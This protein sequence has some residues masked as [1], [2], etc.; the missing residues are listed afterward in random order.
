MPSL[1]KEEEQLS[2][3]PISP[4]AATPEVCIPLKA[5]PLRRPMKSRVAL[6]SVIVFVLVSL[7]ARQVWIGSFIQYISIDSVLSV[8]SVIFSVLE[9]EEGR[10]RGD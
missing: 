6:V 4:M 9:E 7:S 2:S 5:K 10:R 8:V 1:P 3:R